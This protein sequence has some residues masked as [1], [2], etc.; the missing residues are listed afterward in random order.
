VTLWRN[1]V[2]KNLLRPRPEKERPIYK[3]SMAAA[4]DLMGT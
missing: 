4:G 3:A 1:L 2:E